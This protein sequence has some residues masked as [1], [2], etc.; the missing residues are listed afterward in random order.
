MSKIN[1]LKKLS[2]LFDAYQNVLTDIQR[3]VFKQY[4]FDDYSL[5][6]IAENTKTS[7]TSL[8]LKLKSIEEKLLGLEEKIGFVEKV[9]SLNKTIDSLKNKDKK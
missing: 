5:S 8:S 1:K 4:Y 9:E 3:D 7:R 2:L 6:E